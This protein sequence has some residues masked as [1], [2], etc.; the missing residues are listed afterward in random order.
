MNY[1]G[2][3]KLLDLIDY[4]LNGQVQLKVSLNIIFLC[5]AENRKLYGFGTTQE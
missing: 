5:S 3:L 2:S 1:F 4:H